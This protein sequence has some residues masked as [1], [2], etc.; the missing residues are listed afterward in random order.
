MGNDLFFKGGVFNSPFLKGVAVPCSLYIWV[1]AS[2]KALLARGI[3][4]FFCLFQQGDLQK[5]PTPHMSPT[6]ADTSLHGQKPYAL[7]A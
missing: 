5:L 4:L 6:G 1:A 3:C 2:Q 7:S